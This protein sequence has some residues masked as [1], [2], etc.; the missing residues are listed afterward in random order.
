MTKKFKRGDI[1]QGKGEGEGKPIVL[2]TNELGD[3]P[4]AFSGVMVGGQHPQGLYHHSRFWLKDAFIETNK[5][6][7]LENGPRWRKGDVF[8]YAKERYVANTDDTG[9]EWLTFNGGRV[10]FEEAKP[11]GINLYDLESKS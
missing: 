11:L 2:V 9:T 5:K 7:A 4:G 10:L 8:E 3:S 6:L 1:V